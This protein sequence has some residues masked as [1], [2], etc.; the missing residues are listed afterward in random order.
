MD[1]DASEG[2]DRGLFW[3]SNAALAWRYW[4]KPYRL[5]QLHPASNRVSKPGLPE[6]RAGVL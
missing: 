3:N 1:L 6:H 4:E 5:E 2:R